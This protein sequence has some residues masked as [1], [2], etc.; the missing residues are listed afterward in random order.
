MYATLTPAQRDGTACIECG[1][2]TAPM[3]PIGHVDGGQVFQCTS[4]ADDAPET[5]AVLVVGRAASRADKTRLRKAARALTADLGV[6]ATTAEHSDIDVNAF[7]ALYDMGG[8]RGVGD[9]IASLLVGEAFL[10]D[11]PVWERADVD[12]MRQERQGGASCDWC[13]DVIDGGSVAK[14]GKAWAPLHRECADGCRRAARAE[15]KRAA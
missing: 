7:D 12:A 4:H 9:Y 15:E 10:A 6:I 14:V 8:P 11:V 13:G 5:P 2:D 3:V 1:D